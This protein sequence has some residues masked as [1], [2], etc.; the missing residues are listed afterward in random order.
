MLCLFARF[1]QIKHPIEDRIIPSSYLEIFSGCMSAGK[2]SL[3]TRMANTLKNNGEKFRVFSYEKDRHDIT[4]GVLKSKDG[5]EC[6]CR[7]I[8][9]FFDSS[10]SSSSSDERVD[11]RRGKGISETSQQQ[12]QGEKL[13]STIVGGKTSLH[14]DLIIE[15]QIEWVLIDEA[16]F[17]EDVVPFVELLLK[18][19]IRVFVSHLNT[20]FLGKTWPYVEKLGAFAHKNTLLT[21]KCSTI[22]CTEPSIHSLLRN[23]PPSAIQNSHVVL[24]G[25]VIANDVVG[26]STTATDEE[27]GTDTAKTV[28]KYEYFTACNF[29]KTTVYK[30][31]VQ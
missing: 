3:L 22:G 12:Q 25:E 1:Q 14:F 28:E 27:N 8:G 30:S 29:C 16:Q 11:T 26:K 19:N 5:Q 31:C 9:M 15:D 10:S 18:N 6:P 7:F 4:A 24:I 21:G 23:P 2:T 13:S 17:I 20:N